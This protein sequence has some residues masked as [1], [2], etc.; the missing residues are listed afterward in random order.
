MKWVKN[1]HK[2]IGLGEA[3]HGQLKINKWRVKI[4]KTL[5]LKY[6]FTILVLEEEYSCSKILDRYIKNKTNSYIDGISSFGFLNTTFINLLK[7]MRK[8]NMKNNNKLSIIGIDCQEICSEYISNSNTTKYVTNLVKKYN[9]KREMSIRDKYMYKIFMKQFNKQKKYVIFGHN[10][11]LQRT[12]YDAKD[13]MIWFGNYLSNT[14][15][16]KYFV[17]GNTFYSGEYLAKDIDNNYTPSIARIKVK[18]ELKNGLYLINK[19]L[20]TINVY[21]GTVVFSSKDYNKTYY[22]FQLNNRFDALIVINNEL[23]FILP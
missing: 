19:K 5:V 3:T 15:K 8:F 20:Q 11:H 1:Y 7:W 16:N 23:S 17:I 13:K 4:F 18:K 10:G 22:K 6:C 21:E 9:K 12:K 14:F 2:I